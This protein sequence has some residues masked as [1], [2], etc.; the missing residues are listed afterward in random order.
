MNNITQNFKE[1]LLANNCKL[2]Y[3]NHE[4]M[5]V[6]V[7]AKRIEVRIFTKKFFRALYI[8]FIKNDIY[9]ELIA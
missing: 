7:F 5:N 6:R 3:P 2:V 1:Y 8:L 9:T 4:K